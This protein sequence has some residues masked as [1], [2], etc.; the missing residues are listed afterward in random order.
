MRRPRTRSADEPADR[1]DLT[2]RRRIRANGWPV[3]PLR[4]FLAALFC[5]AGYAKFS[6]PRFFEPDSPNGFRSAVEAAKNGHTPLSDVMGPLA[7]HASLFGHLTAVAEIAIG[8]GLLVGLLTR[9]AALGGMILTAMIVLSINWNGVKEYTGSSGWFTSVELALIAALSVFLLGG[10]GPF[11]LDN[12]FIRA[13]ERQRARDDA[14][15]SFRDSEIE[16]SRRRLQGE[17]A[18]GY[19]DGSREPVSREP[20]SGAGTATAQLPATDRQAADRPTADRPTT[21]RPTT[22]RPTAADRSTAD[23]PTAPQPGY[24]PGQQDEEY[25]DD[26]E[27]EPNSLWTQGRRTPDQQSSADQQ[28]PAESRRPVEPSGPGDR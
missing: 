14:E 10:A 22:D 3:L 2:D 1:T 11:A 27:P 20:V 5:F 28:S 9:L 24:R 21:D 4:L 12:L 26:P 18:Q 15:P 19:G 6:Y 13:R 25:R 23:R 17:P 16:D 8:L 7:D